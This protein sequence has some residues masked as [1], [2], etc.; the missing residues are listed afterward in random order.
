MVLPMHLPKS[1][2]TNLPRMCQGTTDLR[3]AFRCARKTLASSFQMDRTAYSP[4]EGYIF[5]QNQNSSGKC[6][7]R[8]ILDALIQS[9]FQRLTH[10][11]P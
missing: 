2:K 3:L 9:V 8:R 5:V 4:G 1:G 10:N 7:L 6:Q 11:S